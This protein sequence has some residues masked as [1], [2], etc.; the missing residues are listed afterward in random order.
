MSGARAQ[1]VPPGAAAWCDAFVAHLRHERGRSP[2]TVAAYRSDVHSVLLHAVTATGQDP[3]PLDLDLLRGWLARERTRGQ[4]PAT[5]ARRASAVRVFTA[6]SARTGWLPADPG[7]RLAVPRTPRPL[8][9][10]L[11]GEQAR[12]V[13]SGLADAVDVRE[14][15]TLRD[16]AMLELLYATG[17][18]VAELVGL[19]LGDLDETR[20]VVRVVGKGDKQRTVPYGVPA[21]QA[22]RAWLRDG[23]HWLTSPRSGAAVFLG[24]RGARIDPR[25]VRRV[26]HAAVR[27]EP[28]APDVGPHGLRHSAATHLLEGGADL[29]SVQELLG[30]ASVATTQRYTHVSIDRLRR[31]YQQAHPRA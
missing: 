25:V 15:T 11:T 19:D 20:R 9:E 17:I 22:L 1:T 24:V 7:A 2:H 30:H 6:W 23:R 4:A 12:D 3:P 14:P 29:R 8:P 10:L 27:L 13:L 16:H 21:E 28:G 18:R 5:L 31:A 26:V